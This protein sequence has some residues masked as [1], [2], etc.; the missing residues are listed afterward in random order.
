MLYFASRK[1]ER[2]KLWTSTSHNFY[3]VKI[4]YLKNKNK[5]TPLPFYNDKK[6]ITAAFTIANETTAMNC[7]SLPPC[8]C[9]CNNR[10]TID[11]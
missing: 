11:F 6:I 5:I 2:K 10:M 1:D 3:E 8:A 7:R 9:Y 4:K